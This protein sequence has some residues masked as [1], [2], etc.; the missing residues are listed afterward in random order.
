[1]CGICGIVLT[2]PGALNP[3]ELRAVLE[4]MTRTLSHRGP[5]DEGFALFGSGACSAQQPAV[6]LGHRRLSIIDPAGGHQPI[7][8]EDETVWTICNGE[9]YNFL[10][11][12]DRLAASGHAFRT[13]SDSEILV[14]LY[15]EQGAEM[16][17]ALRGMFAFAVWDDR[18][19][20]L[21]LARDRLGKKPLYY[22]H[23]RR[24]G[25]F[26]FASELKA[27]LEIPGFDRT[28]SHEAISH[29]L[30]LQYVP[31]PMCVFE[32]ARKLPPAHVLTLRPG[33]GGI[34]IQRYWRPAFVAEEGAPLHRLKEEL[35]QELTEAVRLRLISDVPLGAFLSGGVD[36]SIAV[37]LMSQV[38]GAQVRTFSIGFDEPQYD[39][40]RYARMTA[41]HCHTQHTE[42]TVRPSA[43]EVLPKLV[44]HYDEPFADCSAI[45]TYYV[46]RMA[47][48]HVK[49]VLNGDAGD[50]CFAGYPRY[51]A[52]M[53]SGK[54]DGL[55][56]PLRRVATSQFWASLP[57]P[58]EPKAW[59]RRLRR[60]L[61]DM[62]RS[63]EDRYVGWVSMFD[64][65][66]K[67]A[68]CTDG[69]RAASRWCDPGEFIRGYYKE[70]RTGDFTQRTTYV[71]F[72]TY[73]PCDLLVKMDIAS[74]AHGL[75]ARSPYL[76]HKVVELAGRIPMRYKL[77]LGMLGPQSKFILKE[78]FGDMVPRPVLTRRKMGFGVPI[79]AWFRG[80]L[81]G[82]VRDVLLSRDSLQRGYFVPEQVRRL[83]EDHVS[84]AQD[85]GIRLWVLLM[86]ELWH[87]RFVDGRDFT[88]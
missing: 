72:M 9:V 85:H 76:D 32:C 61:S 82:L 78:T 14:H 48:R 23:D 40:T 12:R 86:L 79:S 33:T 64:D 53:L 41:H 18:N 28:V 69:F 88:I 24:R 66:L 59:R 4:R 26:A 1:M 71:D 30:T 67:S 11:L 68:L 46:S 81:S 63:P 57:A 45:P 50:E 39:E 8:N 37:A 3:A 47:S 51:L 10:D 29:Y 75:E 49:V 73:L 42:E 52:V 16:V 2:G 80:E 36:S 60:F 43:L 74:M 6:G 7:A 56:R 13:R 35:R 20:L 21:L 87:R 55:P 25:I 19:K 77:R 15:E 65:A 70:A 22:V 44:W 58:L 17:Q 62:N 54:I 38:S 5:D 34:A 31:H 83:V 84:G 27:L